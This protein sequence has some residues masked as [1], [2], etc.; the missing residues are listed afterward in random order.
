[1]DSVLYKCCSKRFNHCICIQC[2][3][4]WHKHCILEKIERGEMEQIST[5][6]VICCSINNCKDIDN[7][8]IELEEKNSILEETLNELTYD[9]KLKTTYL[10]RLKLDHTS[11]LNEASV[12]E[13][14]LNIIIKQ[15]EANISE[16]ENKI[17]ALEL[18]LKKYTY[19]T[20]KSCSTQTSVEV[21]D[22][23]T[24][25]TTTKVCNTF[26]QTQIK[27][28]LANKNVQ[29]AYESNKET[30]TKKGKTD[31]LVG[32]K[33]NIILS[34]SKTLELRPVKTLKRTKKVLVYGDG[35]AQ[36]VSG[37]L[38]KQVNSDEYFVEG[39]VKPGADFQ[40]LS[41]C[42][43]EQ[44]KGYNS[45]DFIVM[46]LD[47]NLLNSIKVGYLKSLLSVGR[48]TNLFLVIKCDILKL[49]N[50]YNRVINY[51]NNFCSL[52]N[53]LSIKTICN[54]NDKK[55]YCFTKY[56]LCKK[57][58]HDLKANIVNKKIV[59]KSIDI[60]DPNLEQAEDVSQSVNDI[61]ERD[62][63]PTLTSINDCVSDLITE[64]LDAVVN[65]E[66]VSLK[67]NTTSSNFLYPRLSQWGLM[68]K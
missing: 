7:T 58:S 31:N 12:R 67:S 68:E 15:H 47:L 25:T 57:I 22:S 17:K 39:W 51:I 38:G 24:M 45:N 18:D 66:S 10:E 28:T 27:K 64:L 49:A 20:S 54:I 55:L 43:F 50:V 21:K 8:I 9:S 30:P 29:T 3:A 19:K 63:N 23:T 62:F 26:T 56:K 11:L 40:E 35:S 1:M 52:N 60:T 42:L 59:L 16:L 41:K 32:T 36:N 37:I 4:V 6:K 2:N 44:S 46:C 48:Y 5:N 65:R 61:V 53:N 13:D 34:K 14:E 33:E